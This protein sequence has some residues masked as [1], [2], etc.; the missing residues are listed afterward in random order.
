MIPQAE[1]SFLR[2]AAI[3]LTILFC[4]H[5]G[6]ATA[7]TAAGTIT[8][9]VRSADAVLPNMSVGVYSANDAST[10]LK[11]ARTNTE[12]VFSFTGL[13]VGSYKIYFFSSNTNYISGWYKKN[14]APT[15][16]S[17]VDAFSEGSVVTLTYSAGADIGETQLDLGLTITGKVTKAAVEPAVGI[18]GVYAQAYLNDGTT[19]VKSSAAT[20]AEG[21]YTISGL[22][23]GSYK[24]RFHAYETA[25]ATA[26]YSSA[27]SPA[28]TVPGADQATLVAAG[29]SD[30]IDGQL[31]TGGSI[32]GTVSKI[33]GVNTVPVAGALVVI[34]DSAEPH[35]FRGFITTGADGTYTVPGIL[36]PEGGGK[37]IV[38][39]Y[40]KYV[41][42]IQSGLTEWYD[43]VSANATP[44]EVTITEDADGNKSTISIDAVLDRG[45]ISGKVSYTTGSPVAGVTVKVTPSAGGAEKT[46]ITDA[47]GLYSIPELFSNTLYTVQFWKNGEQI[48]A[49]TDVAAGATSVNLQIEPPPSSKAAKLIPIYK[50]L[51]LKKRCYII[52]GVRVCR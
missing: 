45:P 37:Y 27:S 31:S 43:N 47:K 30:S 14:T 46:A 24:I 4:F 8:G 29:T 19:W 11:A 13:A 41:N 18:A 42:N 34:Y 1:R 20:T 26:W 38:Q 21:N 23:P 3:F 35:A 50:Q 33:D 2:Q 10:W 40:E 17:A 9:V 28:N 16:S 51:L 25:Y 12:G 52:N 7:Q 5:A 22:R 49:R 44:T 32:S 15:P 6:A 48:G 39:F 36:V